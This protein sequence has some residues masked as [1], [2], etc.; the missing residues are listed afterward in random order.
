M[1]VV[2]RRLVV[3]EAGACAAGGGAQTR[4]FRPEAVQGCGAFGVGAGALGMPR[5]TPIGALRRTH[6]GRTICPRHPGTPSRPPHPRT[7]THPPLHRP[8]LSAAPVPAAGGSP[9]GSVN[10]VRGLPW[11]APD[12][13]VKSPIN[14]PAPSSNKAPSELR[15]GPLT[16]GFAPWGRGG[17]CWIRTNVGVSR[18]FYRPFPLAARATRQGAQRAPRAGARIADVAGGAATRLRRTAG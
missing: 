8:A 14:H 5:P 9:N 3:I 6:P 7:G 11:R 18:R 12:S 10:R 15:K 4:T 2:S 17:G 16:W 1:Q 13:D